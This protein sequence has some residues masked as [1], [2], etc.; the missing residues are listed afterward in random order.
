MRSRD[1][2]LQWVRPLHKIICLLDDTIVPVKFGHL[3]AGNITHGHRFLSPGEIKITPPVNS[4]SR[5][6]RPGVTTK[7]NKEDNKFAH[8]KTK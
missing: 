4:S 2:D 8:Q 3:T 1:G 7:D 6:A 5:P